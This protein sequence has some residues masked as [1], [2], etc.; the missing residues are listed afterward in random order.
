MTKL[1]LDC[2]PLARV[3]PR[4]GRIDVYIAAG[5]RCMTLA[6]ARSLRDQLD[7]CIAL[8]DACSGETEP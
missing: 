2:P 3:A 4:P 7:E 1:D 6:E 5:W 8:I